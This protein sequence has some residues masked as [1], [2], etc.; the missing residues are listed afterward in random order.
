MILIKS[1]TDE[2]SM[3]LETGGKMILVL[4]GKELG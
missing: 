4:G 2:R 3:L 1:K